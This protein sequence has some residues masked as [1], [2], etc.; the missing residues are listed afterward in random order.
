MLLRITIAAAASLA[1]VGS[2]AAKEARIGSTT[3]TLPSPGGYCEMTDKDPSD[4]RAMKAIGD[5]LAATKNEML[6]MAADCSQLEAWRA[7]KVPALDDYIQFQVPTDASAADV[8]SNISRAA[9]VKEL[10]ANVRGEA[11]KA[12]SD[13]APD[14]KARMETAVKGAKFNEPSFLGVLAED[15]SACYYGLLQKL[16]TEVGTEKTQLT[17]AALTVV[18]GKVVTYLLY[19]VHRDGADTVT[20]ALGRHQ[21]NVPAL[22]A[23]NGDWSGPEVAKNDQHGGSHDAAPPAPVKEAAAKEADVK[24]PEA[25]VKEQVAAYST[26]SIGPDKLKGRPPASH[27]WRN[28]HCLYKR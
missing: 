26:A 20:A 7:A 9:A 11:G 12:L 8:P 13:A 24:A 17:V 6:S 3:L 19:T 28:G 4:A 15:A 22:L 16:R 5:A 2:A 14:I 25:P 21:R 10:C 23:A 1:I 18:K 27:S